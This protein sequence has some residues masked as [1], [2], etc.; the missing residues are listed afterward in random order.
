MRLI[1]AV[2]LTKDRSRRISQK[3]AALVE[4]ALERKGL[5]ARSVSM[6]VVGH[7]GL[8][9]DIRAGRIPSADRMLAL[10]DFLEIGPPKQRRELDPVLVSALFEELGASSHHGADS[11]DEAPRQEFLAVPFHHDDK[12]H[13]GVGPIALARS[14]LNE[15]GLRP[16]DAYLVSVP[17]DDMAPTLSP[18]DLLLVDA[19]KVLSPDTALSA[20]CFNGA[21]GVGWALAPSKSSAV[22]FFEGRYTLPVVAKGLQFSKFKYIGRVVARFDD[23]P[24]PWI[25]NHER[26]DLFNRAKALVNAV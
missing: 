12:L 14:W 5:S 4:E 16:D 6:E 23:L 26:L 13:R 20:F 17:N 25:S 8:I 19:S 11:N 3:I 10:F 2:I 21:I 1:E 7:D 18:G 9:R 15:K 24:R 22:V